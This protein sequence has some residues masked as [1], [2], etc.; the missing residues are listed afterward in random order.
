MAGSL[1]LPANCSRA[2]DSVNPIA[3]TTWLIPR[4]EAIP[5]TYATSA[6]LCDHSNSPHA[7][8]PNIGKL[9]ISNELGL[10]VKNF[11]PEEAS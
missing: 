3:V 10:M 7:N 5:P 6:F 2:L 9:L 1:N 4:I 8:S 11:F